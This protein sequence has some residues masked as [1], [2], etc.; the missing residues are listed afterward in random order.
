MTTTSSH[1]FL[2]TFQ[3]N[4]EER[5]VKKTSQSKLFKEPAVWRLPLLLMVEIMAFC[6][7]EEIYF[8]N[9]QILDIDTGCFRLENKVKNPEMTAEEITVQQDRVI[10]HKVYEAINSDLAVQVNKLV[11]VWG[12]TLTILPGNG[13][14]TVDPLPFCLVV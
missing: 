7:H 1:G 14:R 5:L 10:V 9:K 12:V 13:T 3:V 2:L 11:S 6:G 4:V 8:Q